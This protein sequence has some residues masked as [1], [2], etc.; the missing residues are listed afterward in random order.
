M[1]SRAA[2]SR[3]VAVDLARLVALVGMM[4]A[5]TMLWEEPGPALEAVLD[6]PPSTLF[7]V[8]GGASVV[9]A[10][11][12]R[13]ARRDVAGAMRETAARGALVLL[14]GLAIA[15]LAP[16]VVVVL[17]PF[18]LAI[19]LA[20]TLLAAP[21]WLL[22]AIAVPLAV[23]GGWAVAS[24][25]RAWGQ[26][27]EALTWQSALARPLD[28]LLDLLLTGVYPLLTWIVYLLLGMLVARAWLAASAAGRE[29]R[30]L[31]RL[32]VA[33]ALL[34]AIGLALSEAGVRLLAGSFDS[35]AAARDA[36]L[37]N[38]YGAALEADPAFQLLAAPHTGTPADIARTVGIALLVVA[39]LG[40]LVAS[41]TARARRAVE[42]LR[43]TGAAPLTVYAVH[44]VLVSVLLAGP[45]PIATGW[46]AWGLQ[47][48]VALALGALLAATGARG[49]L[50]RMVSWVSAR[51][52]GP[53]VGTDRLSLTMPDEVSIGFDVLVPAPRAE[54]WAALT[55]A[56][57][58]PLW[59][60]DPLLPIERCEMEVRP[61]GRYRWAHRTALG[62]HVVAGEYLR[63]EP[64]A[65]LQ[66]TMEVEGRARPGTVLT[67]RLEDAAGGTLVRTHESFPSRRRRDA[68][69]R[70]GAGVAA[71][72]YERLGALLAGGQGV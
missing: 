22:A 5:H 1:T 37:V 26:L 8:L 4:G 23:A 53:T 20:G 34:L 63:V 48:A 61:G 21:S 6:G 72:A 47:A 16:A 69:A 35:L 38:G 25:R 50:E 57:R 70:G 43:A 33:G 39:A 12:A 68:A 71:A 30:M 58:V 7:A 14:I 31:A 27:G 36:L 64:Q 19:A 59:L 28:A 55:D 17:A 42:P 32:A 60:P 15:P 67:L 13:L 49:P 11:R 2:P 29:R 40:L 41:L 65:L 44:V 52:G 54:V 9:L 51:L 3:L 62:E 10:A 56:Q 24:A 45:P 46:G 18:G 66:Q